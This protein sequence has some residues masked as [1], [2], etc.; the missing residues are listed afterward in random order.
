MSPNAS[1]TRDDPGTRN[2][3][4]LGDSNG[5]R[6]AIYPDLVIFGDSSLEN[7][8]R[9]QPKPSLPYLII[10]II[11]IIKRALLKCR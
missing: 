6:A 4:L 11:I 7:S 3:R 9:P 2:G 1:L 10:S 5:M 8:V